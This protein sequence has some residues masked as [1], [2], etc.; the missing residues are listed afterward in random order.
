M[1]GASTATAPPASMRWGRIDCSPGALQT[2]AEGRRRHDHDCRAGSCEPIA[3]RAADPLVQ[4]LP[5]RRVRWRRQT[6]PRRSPHRRHCVVVGGVVVAAHDR[7]LPAGGNAEPGTEEPDM[8]D[9]DDV[10]LAGVLLQP[11]GNLG[12]VAVVGR[13]ILLDDCPVRRDAHEADPGQRDRGNHDTG[14]HGESG[15]QM[16]DPDPSEDSDE[17][18]RRVK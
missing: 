6:V 9:V 10:L 16:C 3:P 11:R 12:D 4:A 8:V 15:N 5:G 17:P 2:L 14:P 7:N 13:P 1:P 18:R